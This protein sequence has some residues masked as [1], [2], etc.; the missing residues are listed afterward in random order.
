MDLC[1]GPRLEGSRDLKARA[2]DSGEAG[3]AGVS[4]GPRMAMDAER[5]EVRA[6]EAEIAALQRACEQ[7]PATWEDASRV[8]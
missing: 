2:G 5:A 7:L 8:R 4:G 1:N 3:G 6:L